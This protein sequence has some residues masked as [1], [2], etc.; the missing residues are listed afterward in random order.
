M[1]Q[2]ADQVELD[3]SILECFEICN[4]VQPSPRSVALRH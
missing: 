2:Y 3:T 4:E 1:L